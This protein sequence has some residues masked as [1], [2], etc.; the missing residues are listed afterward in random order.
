[1]QQHT[2][3]QWRERFCHFVKIK[4]SIAL[5][6]RLQKEQCLIIS[7]P[8]GCGKTS[9]AFHTALQLEN[10]YGFDFMIIFNPDDIIRYASE[11]KKQLFLIDDVFGKF[12]VSK[13]DMFWWKH[14]SEFIQHLMTRN[15]NL[16]LLMTSRL[17]IYHLAKNE[18]KVNFCP[19]NLISKDLAL[20]V[21]D[22]KEMGKCYLP[23]DIKLSDEVILLYEFFPALCANF[24]DCKNENSIQYFTCPVEYIKTDI[25]NISKAS[26][27]SYLTLA[28]LIIC[29]NNVKKDMF[30]LDNNKYDDML[31]SVFKELDFEKKPSKQLL[32][33][34]FI[35]LTDSYVLDKGS[36]FECLHM[37]LFNTLAYCIG[38]SIIRSILR[39]GTTTF[40]TD[41]MQLETS[42]LYPELTLLIPRSSQEVYFERMLLDMKAGFHYIL[43]SNQHKSPEFRKL[44]IQYMTKHLN[45]R[46]LKRGT[47]GATVLHVVSA[48]GYEDYVDFFLKINKPKFFAFNHIVNFTDNLGQTALHKACMK[49]HITIAKLLLDNKAYVDALDKNDRTALDM[50]CSSDLYAT[51]EYLLSRKATIRQKCT[52][53]QSVLHV[54]CKSNHFKIAQLLLENNANVYERDINGHTSLHLACEEGHSEIVNLL[55]KY[56]I[57]KTVDLVDN[58]GRTALYLA[59][60]KNYFP[61]VQSLLDSKAKPDMHTDQIRFP[62]HCACQNGSLEIAKSLITHNASVDIFDKTGCTPLYLACLN[63]HIEVAK[64]LL[65]NKADANKRN[66]IR[67]TPILAACLNNHIEIVKLLLDTKADINCKN[68]DMSTPLHVAFTNNNVD[69]ILLLI[70]YGAL[71]NELDKTNQ[72]PLL[73][74]CLKGYHIVAAELV[75]HGASINMANK[76]GET[77]LFISCKEGHEETVKMLL[78]AGAN[79]NQDTNDGLTPLHTACEGERK[80]IVKVLL[81]AGVDLN[82][83]Y[84]DG[85]KQLDMVCKSQRK[86]IVSLVLKANV[87]VT[88]IDEK[89]PLYMACKDGNEADVQY[90]LDECVNVNEGDKDGITP[91]HVACKEGREQIVTL[92]IK[93]GVN[94]NKGDKNGT[95]P[96]QLAC[97]EGNETI[98]KVLLHSVANVNN[99]DND[100]MTPLHVA[101]KSGSKDIV[102]LL[103]NAGADVNKSDKKGD[104]PLQ[105]VY[106]VDSEDTLNEGSIVS[107]QV[108]VDDIKQINQIN[109]INCKEEREEIAALLLGADTDQNKDDKKETTM[110]ITFTSATK[111]I[112]NLLTPAKS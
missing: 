16:R 108:D 98:V 97:K 52:D 100:G 92:L 47:D 51:V 10:T 104:K 78:N 112:Q 109:P 79:V 1:M 35:A 5:T 18:L 102:T 62:L 43:S 75:R 9:L 40:I 50:A 76:N 2:K 29:D 103:L 65:H 59:S 95:T 49:G 30:N 8:C 111:S 90:L 61:I 86:E 55:L 67:N 106:M 53:L 42:E 19:F 57:E 28:V 96:L 39:Y 87:G 23:D 17:H 6:E 12:S 26:D 58:K 21:D 34:C 15:K 82:M 14:Q 83:N 77:P 66:H 32:S 56:K 105:M 69:I 48:E 22:R 81:N 24:Y 25:A 33:K 93:A 36:S 107:D 27:L 54:A 73:L 91:L 99:S 71:V 41:R 44:Y 85:S 89:S 13:D 94:V 74:A 88:P 110:Q 20:T 37:N 68:K 101:C 45:K 60:A 84:R 38:P 4:A 31:K 11:D 7:G 70:K 80:P 3:K 64:L 63:G 72:T 46:D